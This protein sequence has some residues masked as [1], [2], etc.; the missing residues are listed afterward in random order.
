MIEEILERKLNSSP[1]KE[2]HSPA[3]LRE[4]LPEP[5][6]VSIKTEPDVAPCSVLSMAQ[7][8]SPTSRKLF[9]MPPHVQVRRNRCSDIFAGDTLPT[10]Q[11]R[12]FGGAVSQASTLTELPS[13]KSPLQQRD[14]HCKPPK[15]NKVN[16]WDVLTL[17]D[18]LEVKHEDL[19]RSQKVKDAKLE[20]RKFYESQMLEKVG[21][22]KQL[23][24][25]G[26]EERSLVKQTSEI[27]K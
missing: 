21:K 15:Q 17:Q 11:N 27:A 22:R 25:Q 3:A 23:L 19:A 1:K 13:F 5:Q 10:S 20:M 7:S 14:P 4:A 16:M 18:S 6:P 8:S 24:E 2:V 12:I 9:P 26:L